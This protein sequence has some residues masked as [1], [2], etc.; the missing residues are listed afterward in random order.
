MRS[1]S[2]AAASVRPSCAFPRARSKSKAQGRLRNCGGVRFGKLSVSKHSGHPVNRRPVSFGRLT[3]P[4]DNRGQMESF[5]E[6]NRSRV[7]QP[8][9]IGVDAKREFFSSTG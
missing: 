8:A 4:G 9:Q 6:S 7:N 1:G 3:T 2:L 5:A